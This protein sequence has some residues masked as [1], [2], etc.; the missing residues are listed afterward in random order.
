MNYPIRVLNL[1]GVL[2]RGGA[3]T[4]VMNIYRN[5]DRKKIQFDFI[6]H[7]EQKGAFEDEV[8]QMGGIV[9]HMPKIGVK[10]YLQYVKALRKFFKE[11]TEYRIIHS[12][13]SELGYVAFREAKRAGIPIRICHAH[14][15]PIGF[16]YKTPIRYIFKKLILPI[17]T[18]R[19]ACGVAAGKWQYGKK[20]F[21]VINNGIDVEKFAFN[22]AIRKELREKYML[23]DKIV[24]GHIGRFEPQK[25]HE[26]LITFFSEL[27]KSHP[28]AVLMLIGD[29]S[30]RSVIEKKVEELQLSDKVML[31]GVQSNPEEFLQMF[32]IFAFPSLFEG[33]GIALIEAQCTGVQCIASTGVTSE[34]NITGL[35]EYVSLEDINAWINA[36]EN[37]LAKQE[38]KSYSF[39][40]KEKGFDIKSQASEVQDIYINLA[41]SL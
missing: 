41:S 21:S 22:P 30:R 28:N 1:F 27:V 9:Y 16:N 7:G 34:S 31:M 33:F 26:F 13:L 8:E 40:I 38:R 20:K 4:L 3:E 36:A 24:I 12:H 39:E 15:A 29:G 32:D 10:S 37:K 14:N 25:N 23:E 11:H 18:E 35:V 17:S 19:L 2:D 5:I 6:V